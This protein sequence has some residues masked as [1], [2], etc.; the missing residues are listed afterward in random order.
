MGIKLIIRLKRMIIYNVSHN[1]IKRIIYHAN[2]IGK[3]VCLVVK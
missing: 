3:I 2:E 1:E